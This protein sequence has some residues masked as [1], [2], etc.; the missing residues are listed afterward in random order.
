MSARGF[1]SVRNNAIPYRFQLQVFATE[2]NFQIYSGE[3]FVLALYHLPIEEVSPVFDTH[4]RIPY[5]LLYCQQ[6]TYEFAGGML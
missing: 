3:V 2:F 1:T 5:T 4:D 6:N